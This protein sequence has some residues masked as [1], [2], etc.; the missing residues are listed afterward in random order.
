MSRL[1]KD[2]SFYQKEEQ[3]QKKKIEDLRAANTDAYDVKKQVRA[4]F[5]ASDSA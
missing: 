4:K 5:F 1:H 3:Q 2:L